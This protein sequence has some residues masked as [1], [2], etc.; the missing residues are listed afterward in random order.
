METNKYRSK[1]K[2]APWCWRTPAPNSKINK[3]IFCIWFRLRIVAIIRHFIVTT[4]DC[5][6]LIWDIRDMTTV[7]R[8]HRQFTVLHVH[9]ISWLGDSGVTPELEQ[10]RYR[11]ISTDG[12]VSW[13]ESVLQLERVQH[14]R[15][16]PYS[17]VSL[18]FVLYSTCYLRAVNKCDLLSRNIWIPLHESVIWNV[19]KRRE[20]EN[21]KEWQKKRE[22]RKTGSQFIGF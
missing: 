10:T 3:K 19:V 17:F 20:V 11:A 8:H 14:I 7:A 12:L 4:E 1:L 22:Q 18:Q 6:G 15:S 13:N 2:Q 5:Y 21:W 16:L 9:F